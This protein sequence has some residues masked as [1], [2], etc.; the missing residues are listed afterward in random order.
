MQAEAQ[1]RYA[2][3]RDQPAR[4]LC[5]TTVELHMNAGLMADLP[6]L[7][8]S[9]AE[10]VGLFRTELQFLMRNKVPR[11]GELAALYGR[12]M[13]AA[14]GKRVVFRTL[15]I[16]SDKVLPYMK[17]Q[18]EPNPAMGWR[19]IRVGLDKPGVMRMQLQALIRAA[20]GRPLTVMFP[21]IAQFDEFKDARQ[22]LL[23]EI[24]RERQPGPR[25]A[26]QGRDRRDARDAVASPS[27]RGSSSRWPTS[28]RSAAT[29]SS[30]SSSPPTA[31]TSGCA[32]ATTR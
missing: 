30:S 26:R 23:D 10:G 28:S 13:D 31:R 24:E 17:P 1:K 20:N 9:G 14:H 8:G 11:R 29:T 16:G 4:A 2:D 19:A 27:R 12:V 3:L 15:D 21:F 22:H 25:P 18:D 6:S 7:E 32:A 5:G